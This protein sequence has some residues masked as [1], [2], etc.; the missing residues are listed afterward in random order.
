MWLALELLM[1]QVMNL[2]QCPLDVIAWESRTPPI[3]AINS[4]VTAHAISLRQFV[5]EIAAAT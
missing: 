1:L 2:F 5:I 4:I 3:L